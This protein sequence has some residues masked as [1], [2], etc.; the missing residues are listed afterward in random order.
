MLERIFSTFKEGGPSDNYDPSDPDSYE[1]YIQML[2]RDSR[3]YEGSVLA[4]KRNE[5]QLYYYGY[6]PSLNPDGT[7]YSDSQI[8]EDPNA[9]YEQILGHD[10]ETP[11]K[12]S[13][14]ST[15]VRD[16]VM[17][18]LPSLIRLFAASENVVSLIPRTQADVAAAQQQTNYI[19]YV[20]WQDNPGF[21]ILYGAFKDAMTVRTGFVKWWTDDV[22]EKRRKTFINLN[23]QQLSMIAQADPTAKL[24]EHEDPDQRTG[25]FPRV[26]L[27]F[28]VD[29]PI[30][31][32]AGVPPEEMRLDRFARS[33][34]TSRIVGHER[35]V[36]VDELV[37]MGY[38]REECLDYLQGQATN[39]FTMEAQL[40]NPGRYSGTRAGD[41]VLYG[42]WYIKVDGDGDGL[43][44]LR[45]I[46]TFG[47]DYHIVHDEA[48]NRVKFAVFGVDPISHTIVGD[49]LADYVKDIQKIK[50]NMTRA[51]L[52]SAAESVN[53]KTVVNELN[54][55]LDDVLND[56]VGA[57][58]RTRG[59][60]QNA[61]AFNNVPFL[62]AQMLPLFELMNDVL[63]RRTGLS[64]AAKGLDAKA[65]QSSSQIGVEAIINGAQER[66]ELVARVL[67]E[68]GFK[69]LF[70]GLY[71]EICEA[72]NQRRTLRING[73]WNDVDTSTFDA[74]MGVEVNST[75]GKGSDTVRM[76]T[77][78]QIKADQAAIFQQFGPNNPVVGIPEMINTISDILELSNIKNVGR[79]F[80]TPT[81][82][83]LQAIATAPKEPDAMTLA[84]QA[85]FQ[86]VK[87][88]TAT[89]VGQQNLAQQKQQADDDFRRQQLAEKTVND[90][91]KIQLEAQKLHVSHVE[92]IGKMAADMWGSQMDAGAQHH[93]ALQDAAVGH[94]QAMSDAAVGF[95]KAN[96]EASV[97][98]HQAQADVQ[99][100]QIQ[101]AAQPDDSG[102]S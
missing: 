87:A 8:I 4:A 3:D 49:S 68:T 97:G 37:A 26:V 27:E 65:L 10:K 48:A 57:I 7:P 35:I 80:K 21:L 15:D 88:D 73:S 72:P 84:A 63:Q 5:A 94:L 1:P 101:A 38:D 18:M 19:N 86:K 85:Q 76:M 2:I 75:L 90:R 33:F 45:Y 78:Q 58:I 67:A 64:D 14:V 98:H 50:T 96:Q 43:A 28:E 62:G 66:T 79:Y 23:P 93:Q 55:D 102:G 60:V 40:R 32:V 70:T 42:E 17:L 100:A 41:G 53:P 56:D 91:A 47:D 54:T 99:A 29:K 77:L 81:P 92:N 11:N 59:D 52:D 36:P 30:I 69:D 46:C 51:V 82:Q 83:Q 34:S 13:Y 25:L 22:K 89:A 95:H 71:N 9:T 31:K 12:S 39:E 74:S 61:V 6:Y 16:A 44:E 24:V 20:F